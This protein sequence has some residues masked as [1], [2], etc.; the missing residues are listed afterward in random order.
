MD[1]TAVRLL[2]IAAFTCLFVT[3]AAGVRRH[4]SPSAQ[5][6]AGV[7][8]ESDDLQ[9]LLH[10]QEELR[11]LLSE[12]E[13]EAD[14]V[15]KNL[16]RVQ[17]VITL[18]EKLESLHRK[19]EDEDDDE[20]IEQ[21]EREAEKIE[22]IIEQHRQIYELEGFRAELLTYPGML[23]EL[24]FDFDHT[25]VAQKLGDVAETI[26]QLQALHEELIGTGDAESSE[27][28]WETIDKLEGRL[29][30]EE[31]LLELVDEI[32]IATEEED[33]DSIDDLVQK[34]STE[35][36]GSDKTKPKKEQTEKNLPAFDTESLPVAINEKSLDE[37]HDVDFNSSIVPMLQKH[38]FDCHSNDSSLGDLDIESMIAQRPLVAN[39]QKWLNV[40]EQLK[41][42]VMPPKDETELP[43]NDRRMLV[44][45]LHNNIHNFDY[46]QVKHPG[47][48]STRRLTLAEY[49]NTLSDLFGVEIKVAER[50]PKE[51]AGT[52][53]FDNSANTLFIQPLLMERFISAADEVV[54]SLLPDKPSTNRQKKAHRRLFF[55]KPETAAA[56]SQVAGKILSRFV[57][58]AYRRPLTTEE[59]KSLAVQYDKLKSDSTDHEQAIKRIVQKTLIS[60]SFLLKFE[61][62][63]NTDDQYKINDWELA[64]R[65]SYFLWASMPD[66]ELFQLASQGKLHRPEILRQ[67][68]DR[69]LDDPR[70]ETLGETFAAQWLGSQHL[71]TRVRL[72]PIDNPWCTESLMKAMRDETSLFMHELIRDD[73]P[74]EQIIN[75]DFTY[76]NEELA[77]HYGIRGVSG[78]QMQRVELNNQN[79]GG[80]LGH[81]S[82]LAV[83][84]F[85][86]RTS[87]VVRGKWIL[88]TIFGTPPPAPPPNVSELSDE[89]EENERLTMREK[90]EIHRKSPNCYACH[91]QMDPLGLALE[92]YDWFGRYRNRLH[93]HRIDDKG[94]LPDGTQFKGLPGLK[95]VILETRK[96]D[97]VRQVATRMLSYALGR[98]LEYYDEPAIRKIL[99]ELQNRENRFRSLIH[100]VVQSHPFQYKKLTSTEDKT[101]RAN[102]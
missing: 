60:P 30:K 5:A 61:T 91:S 102:Q 53:G 33:F 13:N 70:A 87:P 43:E 8:Q 10:E 88:E 24:E 52:S 32:V 1:P 22:F 18:Q 96:E 69:M 49:D 39:R 15:R 17:H 19:I 66:H 47:F 48:E 36:S 68:V 54:E 89:I 3:D 23:E 75:A 81:G 73:A 67:Q 20:A 44:L 98:Q 2:A 78:E 37:F 74:I 28:V 12:L 21:L 85:P 101:G 56:E 64:S 72:D 83:T 14:Q 55:Q 100:G 9:E 6:N 51:L 4:A 80:I 93:G 63:P 29:A 45:S 95:E 16:K 97:L 26:S 38:C 77:K 71:G 35:L 62:H 11:E 76:L 42:R 58:R 99:L 82:I 84:S 86:Y 79:R 46:S 59:R 65:L 94:T 50:F 34:L 7:I 41:N 57:G 90:L 25:V 92:R 40:I 27:S 31:G